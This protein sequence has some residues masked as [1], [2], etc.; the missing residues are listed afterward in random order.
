MTV[1][2]ETIIASSIVVY[3]N[4]DTQKEAILK[5]NKGKAGIY[6]WINIQS[7]NKYIGSSIDLKKRIMNYYN[8]KY[9]TRTSKS[10]NISKAL[11]KWG[12]SAF[13]LEILEYCE[14]SLIIMREQYYIDLLNPEYNILKIAGSFFGYKHSPESLKKM[15]DIAKNRSPDTIAKLREAALGKTYKHK[16]ETKIKLREIMLGRTHSQISKNKMSAFQSNRTNHPIKGFITRV[17]NIQTG[18]IFIYNSLRE[19]G[20]GLNSNHKTVKNYLNTGKVFRNKYYITSFKTEGAQA[21]E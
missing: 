1:I 6:C 14:P 5:H 3:T 4:A 18:Q 15:S 16:E 17:E 13:R 9:L 21:E 12:Y 10:S 7:G 19:T 11:I 20:K 2:Q 8:I